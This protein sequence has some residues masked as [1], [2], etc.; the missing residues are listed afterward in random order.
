MLAASRHG[1]GSDVATTRVDG[2]VGVPFYAP[3][4]RSAHGLTGVREERNHQ[5]VTGIEHVTL[6]EC[7]G[8]YFIHGEQKV[9]DPLK[10]GVLD[11]LHMTATNHV[12]IGKESNRLVDDFAA[13]TNERIP[14]NIDS[15]TQTYSQR[16]DKDRLM[17]FPSET[18]KRQPA[19]R[20][21]RCTMR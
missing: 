12:L 7:L 6:A 19:Y 8:E 9:A 1:I 3:F 10:I 11:R 17:A 21:G 18:C 15:V 4:A 5:D 20:V 14:Q 2:L 16:V 13:Q